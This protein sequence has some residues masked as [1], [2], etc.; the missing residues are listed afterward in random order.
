MADSKTFYTDL[1]YIESMD[2]IG[3]DDRFRELPEDWVIFITDIKGSTKA[4][5]EGRYRQVN[6]IGASVIAAVKNNLG[7][8][9]FPFVFGGDGATLIVHRDFLDDVLSVLYGLKEQSALV[10][11][12]ELRVG[13]IYYSELLKRRAK[14]MV[15]KMKYSDFFYQAVFKGGG[16]EAA[17][18]LI[19]SGNYSQSKM[20]TPLKA[21]L[22]G[23]ECR[24]EDIKPPAGDVVA[25]LVKSVSRTLPESDVYMSVLAFLKELEEEEEGFHPIKNAK[26]KLTMSIKRF[27]NETNARVMPPAFIRKTQYLANLIYAVVMGK[28]LMRFKISTS[29]TNWGEYKKYLVINTDYRKFDEMLRMVISINE[30]K[31][32]RLENFLESLY[33]RGHIVYGMHISQKALLT[34]LVSKYEKDHIHFVDAAGGGYA[35][36]AVQ[37][38]KQLKEIR[39]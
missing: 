4:I 34:C 16:L 3:L 5:Q 27:L 31:R 17:E 39:N 20:E 25:L 7:S 1:P 22:T 32:K 13:Y 12:L 26:L 37:L 14:V 18:T 30:E 9:E 21:D 11:K 24:W 19:K 10:Y 15:S 6:T 2:E 38:K 28:I 29:Q 8:L 33:Q 35:S 36:A 23:L